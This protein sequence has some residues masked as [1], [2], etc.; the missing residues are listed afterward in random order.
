MNM[1]AYGIL[2]CLRVYK[3]VITGHSKKH[4]KGSNLN[5]NQSEALKEM[6]DF[7]NVLHFNEKEKFTLR[8][9]KV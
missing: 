3:E 6:T 9:T 8:F 7:I 4:C 2:Y 1:D 5:E